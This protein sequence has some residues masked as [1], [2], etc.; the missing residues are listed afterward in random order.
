[1]LSIQAMGTGTTEQTHRAPALLHTLWAILYKKN[2][3]AGGEPHV[4]AA[5]SSP[6]T[7]RPGPSLVCAA[8]KCHF[9]IT[10]ST[11]TC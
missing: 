3:L 9:T 8:D 7:S 5:R 2:P 10:A 6:L 4:D 1:M 11:S